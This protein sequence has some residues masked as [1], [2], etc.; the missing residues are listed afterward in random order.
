VDDESDIEI[1]SVIMHTK[2]AVL[3]RSYLPQTEDFFKYKDEII[4]KLI[5]ELN[6]DLSAQFESVY[7]TPDDQGNEDMKSRTC[8]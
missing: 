1:V 5:E 3:L 4:Y 2:D 8:I 7:A 6:G